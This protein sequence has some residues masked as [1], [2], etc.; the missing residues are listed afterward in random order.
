[1]DKR[2]DR[3]VIVSA[4]EFDLRHYWAAYFTSCR[5]ALALAYSVMVQNTTTAETVRRLAVLIATGFHVLPQNDHLVAKLSW[6]CH[7]RLAL[8]CMPKK[9]QSL[10]LLQNDFLLL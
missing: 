5:S 1:M 4:L 9:Q 7:A 10:L 8:A 2:V 3:A 6:T